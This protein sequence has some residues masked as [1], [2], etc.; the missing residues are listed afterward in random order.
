[1]KQ[2]KTNAM[3]ILEQNKIT[4]KPMYYDLANAEFSGEAVSA[5][6]GTPEEQGFKTLT[7][8]GASGAVLVFVVPVSGE[9]NLKKAAKAAGEKK[10]ELL[11]VKELLATT[12]YTRGEVS[13]IGMKKLYPTFIDSSAL[14]FEEIGVSAGKKGASLMAA[15]QSLAD[16]AQAVFAE[17]V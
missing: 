3:R 7:A 12:G 13:P 10:V 4:Y 9:L 2:Q 16:V 5:L 17:L 15:P 14:N 1:M 6:L 11:P 8:K